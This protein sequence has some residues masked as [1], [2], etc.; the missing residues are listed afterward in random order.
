MATSSIRSELCLESLS[1]K[2]LPYD[3]VEAVEAK[4]VRDDWSALFVCLY[5]PPPSKQNRLKNSMFL[6]D[7]PD[8]TS[9]FT[10]SSNIV[11][12]GDFNFKFDDPSWPDVKHITTLLNDHNLTQLIQE[13]THVR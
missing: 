2:L 3:S 12:L 7:L 5:R 6:V 10:S 9:P 8:F 11:L 4:L 13:P 1:A